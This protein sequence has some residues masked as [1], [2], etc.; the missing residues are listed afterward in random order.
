MLM[1]R[2]CLVSLLLGDTYRRSAC[3][4]DQWQLQ[5]F[6]GHLFLASIRVEEFDVLMLVGVLLIRYIECWYGIAT[7][8]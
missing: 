1:Y 3:S 6:D 2:V 8:N 7:T 5:S 4:Q